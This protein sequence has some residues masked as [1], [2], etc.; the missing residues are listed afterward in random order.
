MPC[1]PGATFLDA[2]TVCSPCFPAAAHTPHDSEVLQSIV[3]C[4]E[5]HPLADSSDVFWHLSCHQVAARTATTS[6]K[7]QTCQ[8]G[9]IVRRVWCSDRRKAA[10]KLASRQTI[11]RS[12]VRKTFGVLPSLSAGGAGARLQSLASALTMHDGAP[13][14]LTRADP[15]SIQSTAPSSLASENV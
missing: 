1:T 6:L 10:S 7:G 14:L 8:E 13:L 4:S 15:P 5:N 2:L 12:A 9:H 3:L 11:C